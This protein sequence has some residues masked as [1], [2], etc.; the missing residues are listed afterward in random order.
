M[1]QAMPDVPGVGGD[2]V[3]RPTVGFA[4]DRRCAAITG[5]LAT[6]VVGVVACGSGADMAR[7]T[8]ASTTNPSTSS[9]GQSFTNSAQQQAMTAYLGMWRDFALAGL[10]SDWQSPELSKYATGAALSTL[11]R[12]LYA[13]HYNGLVT[14]G[15]ATHDPSVSSADPA[16]D[17]TT[18]L[19]TDCSDSTHYLKYYASSGSAAD[20]GP[21]GRQRI[22]A[23]VRK[24]LDGS[25][26]VTD[27]GVQAVGTC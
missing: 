16:S 6:V 18:V 26:K 1:P 21:G 23:T 24:Q 7:E 9:L 22:E 25:W 20:D 27:F 8:P 3:F 13:D 12:G 10:H 19:I 5:I 4:V 14:R 17:P 11:S 15:S 2:V